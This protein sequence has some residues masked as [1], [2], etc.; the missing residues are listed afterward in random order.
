MMSYLFTIPELTIKIMH[1]RH[2]EKERKTERERERE[3]VALGSRRIRLQGKT[4]QLF[5]LF[6]TPHVQLVHVFVTVDICGAPSLI[7]K[8]CIRALV[9]SS[10]HATSTC[11]NQL[12]A[13]ELL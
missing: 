9:H 6:F 8:P 4:R 5:D 10:M 11:D 3:V 12:F 1:G 7:S 2:G 13:R